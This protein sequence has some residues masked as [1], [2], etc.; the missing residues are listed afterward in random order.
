MRGTQAALLEAQS[1][2][3]SFVQVMQSALKFGEC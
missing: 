2:L 1:E 3:Q